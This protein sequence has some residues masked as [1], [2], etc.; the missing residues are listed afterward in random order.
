[1][2]EPVSQSENRAPTRTYA[3]RAR[4]EATAPDVIAGIFYLYDV[5]V[6][7][8]IDPGSTHSYI[9]TMLA[10]EKKLSVEATDYDIQVT[11]PLGQSVIVNLICRNFP[12][13]ME[14][15]EFLTDLML[16]PFREFDIILGMG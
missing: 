5:T 14:G 15:Y 11:N 10:S 12:L 8:L 4:E 6:Y 1:M 9:C 2:R 13:K 16:L 3:I 7:A